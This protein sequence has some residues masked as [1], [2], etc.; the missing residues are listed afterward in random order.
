MR[1]AVQG[2]RGCELYRDATQAV[3][4]EGPARAKVVLVGETPGDVE[5]VQGRPFVG[6]AG[7][8]LER[9][10]EEAGFDRREVYVTNAVKHF[11]WRPAERGKRRIH[12]TPT[13][14]HIMACRPWLVAEL[15]VIS[16]QLVVVLGSVAAQSLL[17]PAF[18]V[19]QS[20]GEVL[21]WPQSAQHPADF[22]RAKGHLVATVHP[23]SVLR[24]DDREEAYTNFLKDLVAAFKAM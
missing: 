21:P 23:S 5:D 9:G 15:N 7:R 2:C 22:P 20:R 6:P 16:P 4:G 24:A 11:R 13:R 3:F 12:Q 1:D 19:T 8:V 17:G 14:T 18:R 10:L